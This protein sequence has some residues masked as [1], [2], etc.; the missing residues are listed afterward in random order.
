MKRMQS[1]GRQYKTKESE[2]RADKGA[3]AH[4]RTRALAHMTE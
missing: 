3:N 1:E 4:W 2:I